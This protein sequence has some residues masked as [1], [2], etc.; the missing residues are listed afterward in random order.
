[1]TSLTKGNRKNYSVNYF[2]SKKFKTIKTTLITFVRDRTMSTLS[3][4]G[5]RLIASVLLLTSVAAC[6]GSEQ[7]SSSLYYQP[8]LY[9][10]Q[11]SS[12]YGMDLYMARGG[13]G[14]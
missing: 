3:S 2:K 6:A 5:L 14:Y 8:S 7:S 12:S 9:G 13:Y 11:P 10:Y 1:M 4:F